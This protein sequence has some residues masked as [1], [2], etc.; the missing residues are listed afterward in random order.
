MVAKSSVLVLVKSVW[1]LTWNHSLPL[2]LYLELHLIYVAC[3]NARLI[4][5]TI[6][7]MYLCVYYII[8]PKLSRIL[9]VW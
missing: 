9:S 8:D 2:P 3:I 4:E 5:H 1:V 7:V 6:I